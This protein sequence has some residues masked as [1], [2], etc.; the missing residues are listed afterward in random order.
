[1]LPAAFFTLVQSVH[2]L[3]SQL[4]QWKEPNHCSEA[5][6]SRPPACGEEERPQAVSCRIGE[7]KR[8][9]VLRLNELLERTERELFEARTHLDAKVSSL[10][11]TPRHTI[12]PCRPNLN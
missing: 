8:D 11:M 1:M 4:E 3:T 12:P 6:Y 2:Q 10:Y 9:E 7:D 5:K